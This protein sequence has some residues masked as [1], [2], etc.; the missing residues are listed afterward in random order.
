MSTAVRLLRSYP[1]SLFLV[2]LLAGG[3]VRVHVPK[4]STRPGGKAHEL[5]E[6]VEFLAQ[7][8]LKGRKSRSIESWYVRQYLRQQFESYGL[9][10]WGQ[11]SSLE[12][13]FGFGT[14]VVGVLRGADPRLADEIVLVAAH[15][16]GLGVQNGKVYPCAAS[17]ATGVAILLQLAEKLGAERR[18]LRRSVA[19]AA[20]DCGKERNLGA[21]AFTLRK[22]FD[23][24]KLAAVIGL[25]L[26][27]RNN[28]GIIRNTLI[29]V[30]TDGYPDIRR[31]IEAAA[32]RTATAPATARAAVETPA[33]TLATVEGAAS[34][35][36]R[37]MSAC[38]DL[39][40]PISDYFAFEQW[41][42]PVLLFTNGLYR[43][44]HKP[45]DTAD[46]ID[47]VLLQR[48]ADVVRQTVR[49]LA[50]TDERPTRIRPDQADR[51]ELQAILTTLE[52]VLAQAE[53]LD[54][55]PLESQQLGQLARRARQ[56]LAGGE[57]TLADRKAFLQELAE[58][59]APSIIRFFH[60]PP[61]PDPARIF[62]PRR[63]AEA[64]TWYE[65]LASHRAFAS[66]A[67]QQVVRYFL[68]SRGNLLRLLTSYT[69]ESGDIHSD[70]ISFRKEQA[71]R[72][73]LSFLYPHLRIQAGIFARDLN[74]KYEAGDCRGTIGEI[75]DYCLLYW[76]LGEEACMS[77][78][79]PAVLATVTGRDE[80]ASYKDWLTWRMRQVGADDEAEYEYGLWQTRSGDVLKLLLKEAAGRRRPNIPEDALSQIIT[81]RRM[82]PDV[83][84]DAIA[85][86]DAGA[87]KDLLVAL[88]DTLED[89]T[90][91]QSRRY[92]PAFDPT[93]PFYDHVAVRQIRLLSPPQPGTTIGAAAHG[94]LKALTGQDLP[95]EASVWREWLIRKG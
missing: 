26:L 33:A 48:D 15:Y 1:A 69:Y 54:L 46:R 18:S 3:C 60:D 73:R 25:D 88:A 35:P 75:V 36:L 14:N 86:V 42:V 40:P 89:T 17:D 95:A 24:S 12:E 43:E 6:H 11:A 72:Y 76:S 87:G 44:Y 74:V 32:A 39:V 62:S 10:P 52:E 28:F 78:V 90:P 55:T 9:A 50:D 31:A 92:V 23:P 85:A 64:L 63:M 13:S 38:S 80:G 83:R 34:D 41:P 91:V 51:D 53:P 58:K 45:T 56:L 5:A 47:Y 61:K 2:L 93:F 8:D 16:D 4:P 82:R 65:M 29:V 71:D 67:T 66:R 30:G 94:R 20:F 81:D 79:M 70:E 59:G 7:P 77:R 22:D 37:I 57:Y 84:A 68:D 21:F 49:Y 27:G 19:F